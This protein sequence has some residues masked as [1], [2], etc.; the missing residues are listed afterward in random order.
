MRKFLRQ[1]DT[2]IV[3]H[4]IEKTT[5]LCGEIDCDEVCKDCMVLKVLSVV[6]RLADPSADVIDPRK[7]GAVTHVN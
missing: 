6:A 4:L 1:D 2:E 5:A 3:Q 7:S